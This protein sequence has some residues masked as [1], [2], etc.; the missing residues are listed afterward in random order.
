MRSTSGGSCVAAS[1]RPLGSVLK[2]DGVV[3][4][5]M[6]EARRG[7]GPQD[8]GMQVVYARWCMP[9]PRWPASRK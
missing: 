4:T 2:C 1:T 8:R 5:F 3:S 9:S 7:G 6:A